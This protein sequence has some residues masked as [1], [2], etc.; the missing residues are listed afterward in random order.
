MQCLEGGTQAWTYVCD[1]ADAG[2]F[3]LQ[4]GGVAGEGLLPM[5]RVKRREEGPVQP[6][7][8]VSVYRSQ[9]R[10]QDPV[11][12]QGNLQEGF[13][14]RG[15]YLHAVHLRLPSAG[16]P[17]AAVVGVEGVENPLGGDRG[18]GVVQVDAVL[19]PDVFL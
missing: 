10:D 2:R 18:S 12:G 16:L 19:L 17:L 11:L 3:D 8:R 15:S 5:P 14:D 9:T 4:L 1:F 6:G 7:L 13:R